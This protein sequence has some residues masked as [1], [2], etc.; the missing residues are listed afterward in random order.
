MLGV[1]ASSETLRP[2]TSDGT[3]GTREIVLGVENP[4]FSPLG[5]ISRHLVSA[6]LT[7]EDRRFWRHGGFDAAMLGRALSHD[8]AVGRIEKGAS[9][10]T[11]QL[12]KNMFLS[13]DRTLGR[14]L[15]EAVIAWRMEQLLSKRRILELYLNAIELG[16]GLYGV[17][18]AA[19]YYFGK[20]P[21]DLG[22]LE[23]AHLAALTP[24]PR[25]FAR[26]FGG[27]DGASERWLNHLYDL[28]A[29]MRRSNRLT[30]E[31]AATARARGLRLRP[32]G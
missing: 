27:E 25:L 7:A 17:H 24:N 4:S 15:E 31:E 32:H 13:K 26:R 1:A 23:A 30:A 14:K 11:Q 19:Q 21:S 8:I 18:E 20:L 9:T 22:P 2:R 3:G 5:R 16:P 12:A 29:M 6:F 28:I 10:I